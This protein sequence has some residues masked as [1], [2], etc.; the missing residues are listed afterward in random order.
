MSFC[1][2]FSFEFARRQ[3]CARYDS[4]RLR[5]AAQ[6]RKPRKQPGKGKECQANSCEP[7]LEEIEII[8]TSQVGCVPCRKKSLRGYISSKFIWISGQMIRPLP[9]FLTSSVRMPRS[10]TAYCGLCCV[11]YSVSCVRPMRGSCATPRP[12]GYNATTYKQ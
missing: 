6:F 12:I 9:D 7:H 8:G 1:G 10:E 5:S 3:V 11:A 2:Y 4:F